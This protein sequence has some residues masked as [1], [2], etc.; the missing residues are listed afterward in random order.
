MNKYICNNCGDEWE[1]LPE[2]Y[3]YN[4]EYYPKKCPLCS[5]TITQMIRDTFVSGGITETI[6]MIYKRLIKKN[7]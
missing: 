2:D 3:D 7:I 6:S 5:M 1:F 4:K